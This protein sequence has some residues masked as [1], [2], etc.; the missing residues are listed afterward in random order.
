MRRGQSTI[1]LL[2]LLGVALGLTLLIAIAARADGD[3]VRRHLIESIPGHRPERRDDRWALRSDPYGPLIRRY[4]PTMILERD[5]YNEDAAVP[6]DP[7][8]CRKP[9]CAAFGTGRP[10]MF[11][12]VVRQSGSAASA[13]VVVGSA[14]GGGVGVGGGGAQGV[15]YIQYWFYYPDSK[16]LHVPVADLQGYHR[17]DWEGMI[18]RIPDDGEPAAR[19][20]AHQGLVGAARGWTAGAGGVTVAADPGWRPIAAHPTIYRAAGSH[21]NGFTRDGI[22]L[23]LDRWNGDLG[24]IPW[25]RFTLIAA[26]TA[27]ALRFRYDPAATPPWMKAL[28]ANPEASGTGRSLTRAGR[29]L[30]RAGRSRLTT[31]RPRGG[32]V[33][34]DRFTSRSS[35]RLGDTPHG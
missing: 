2:V 13:G 24:T 20:T 6:S 8:V 1:E 4:V 11:T 22:D 19:V 12:H 5:R 25:Q 15:T 34:K 16:T 31:G 35:R 18:V 10:T 29:S 26:D 9:W 32:S 7:G 28:W 23:P 17:D 14:S 30:T 27:P 3:S 33:R 21:A